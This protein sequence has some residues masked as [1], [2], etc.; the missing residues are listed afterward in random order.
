VVHAWFP[1][2]TWLPPHGH[3]DTNFA[4]MLEGSFDLTRQG[5]TLACP[6]G[7]AL[8]EPAG[9]RHAN[10]MGSHGAEVIVIQPR[11]E[12]TDLF[13]TTTHLL[14]RP[15]HTVHGGIRSGAAAIVRELDAPDALSVLA[16]EGQL[17][18]MLAA[19]GRCAGRP[20]R[21]ASLPPWL[22]RV[23]DR[24]HAASIVPVRIAELAREAQVE[25]VTLARAFRR[26]YRVP[27]GSYARRLRLERCAALLRESGTPLAAVALAGGF[28]DQSHFTRA[29]RQRYGTT[30]QAFR[31][32]DTGG[33]RS[34]PGSGISA[35]SR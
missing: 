18:L 29:F 13:R 17:L 6:P 10:R 35:I 3:E 22:L 4:V 25:P 23:V 28:A 19:L 21:E 26:F 34:S 31:L 27:L 1:A 24:L 7:A 11:P 16:I 2:G 8:V 33:R 12:A 20:G 5:R 32:S 15:G 9:E 14:E 30:P